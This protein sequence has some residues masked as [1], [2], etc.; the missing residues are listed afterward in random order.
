[1]KLDVLA[2]NSKVGNLSGQP[3][4]L[5]LEPLLLFPK[6]D[7]FQRCE[8]DRECAERAQTQ[9]KAELQSKG[10]VRNH[11]KKDCGPLGT[12]EID[13]ADAKGGYHEVKTGRVAYNKQIKKQIEKDAHILRNDP[14]CKGITWHFSPGNQGEPD[15]RVI[16]HLREVGV[17]VEFHDFLEAS[18]RVSDLVVAAGKVA[19][20]LHWLQN[21]W[22]YLLLMMVGMIFF[23]MIGDPFLGM[24]GESKPA[25]KVQAKENNEEE[26]NDDEDGSQRGE[27]PRKTH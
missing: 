14:E 27:P 13:F 26:E 20:W 9:V 2:Q 1:M 24:M 17:H 11:V 4:V 15:K 22:S 16:R 21:I 18:R 5:G 8:I 3:W 25:G 23:A 10:P 7:L 19:E 12:R 6:L